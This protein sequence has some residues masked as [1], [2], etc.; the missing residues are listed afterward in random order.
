M[1]IPTLR[2]QVIAASIALLASSPAWAKDVLVHPE[3]AGRTLIA[4]DSNSPDRLAISGHV[5]DCPSYKAV[6]MSLD[7]AKTWSPKCLPV[8]H[9]SYTLGETPSVAFDGTGAI[10]AAAAMESD[11]DSSALFII[12]SADAGQTWSNWKYVAAPSSTH[13]HMRNA[14]VYVD[15][16]PNSPFRGSI[17]IAHI[18]SEEEGRQPRIAFSRDGGERW[19]R[20]GTTPSHED[21]TMTANSLA[22]GAHGELHMVYGKCHQN[23]RMMS[24]HHVSSKDGGVTWSTP[25]KVA[26]VPELS[27]LPGTE[28]WPAFEPSLAIDAS[29]GPRRGELHVS[30][31]SAIDGRLQVVTSRSED[32]GRHWTAPQVVSPAPADQF[33]P[34]I[35]VN[36]KGE[37]A[38]VWLDR[39]NDPDNLRYQ[40]VAAFSSDGGRSFGE[41]QVLDQDL[42]D[43]LLHPGSTLTAP[44]SHAWAGRSV[45]AAFLSVGQ[46]GQLTVRSS[47]AKP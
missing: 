32:G 19:S 28:L 33:M 26:E 8:I 23:C 47:H 17:Y 11:F 36:P 20:Y 6:H 18:V 9:D 24:V 10:W 40:P 29:H 7:R 1:R 35:S 43:P 14:R 22:I 38:A 12:H 30:M 4:A 42:T 27:D 46:R 44:A 45:Q 21:V 16:H 13:G 5:D 2:Q 34:T 3:G 41:P 39:R 15:D 37:M 31:H 25:R